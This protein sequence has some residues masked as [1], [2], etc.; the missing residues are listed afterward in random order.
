MVQDDVSSGDQTTVDAIG[1]ATEAIEYIEPARG[2]L[3]A[4]HQLSGRADVPFEDSAVRLAEAGH[5]DEAAP[6]WRSLVGRD[7]LEGRWTFEIVERF[8]DDY[9][10][11]ARSEVAHLEQARGGG[12]R[13]AHE[14]E[15][16]RQRRAQ[17]RPRGTVRVAA[18]S[19]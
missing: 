17:R 18:H 4:F 2:H 16:R 6:P 7:V 3:Y 11:V 15:L 1:K 9:Y 8:D 13:H 12:R 10:D 14:E 5:R 19:D